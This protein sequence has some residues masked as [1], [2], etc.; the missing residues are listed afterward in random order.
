MHLTHARE[1]SVFFS[2]IPSHVDAFVPS[3]HKFTHSVAIGIGLFCLRIRSRTLTFYFLVTVESTTV[4]TFLKAFLP[5]PLCLHL[6]LMLQ[7]DRCDCHHGCP[8]T[9]F[10]LCTIFWQAAP[11]LRHYWRL[12]SMN[13]IFFAHNKSDHI[14]EFFFGS[15]LQRGCHL[16]INL[17]SE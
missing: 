7:A 6:S 8:S 17:S 15:S 11:S 5:L 2:T 13:E 1:I 14:S 3:W 9:I 16:H 4:S 12:I 10:D